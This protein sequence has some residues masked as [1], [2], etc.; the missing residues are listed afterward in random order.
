MTRAALALLL[1]LAALSAA[2]ALAQPPLQAAP[3]P[4]PGDVCVVSTTRTMEC[5]SGPAIVGQARAIDGD[6]LD[7]GGVRVR[8]HGIDAPELRQTCAGRDG[9]TYECGRDARAVLSELVRGRTVTC[10]ARDTDRYHRIVAT[11]TTDAGDLGE[12]MVRRGWALP[13]LRYGGA[14]YLPAEVEAKRERLGV[15]SGRFQAPEDFRR[16]R[17]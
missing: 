1:A 15:H 4:K 16:A 9:R 7:V 13:Y 11:C 3:D 14:L 2:L 6:T 10:V 8:L 5:R 12:Q 17:R